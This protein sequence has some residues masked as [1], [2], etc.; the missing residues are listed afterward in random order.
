M[1]AAT[2]PTITTENPGVVNLPHPEKGQADG[3]T[4]RQVLRERDD[5]RPKR[6]RNPTGGDGFSTLSVP[7]LPLD[8]L[9]RL[10]DLA[11]ALG[12]PANRVRRMCPQ[13]VRVIADRCY[14]NL[15]TLWE[16]APEVTHENREPEFVHVKLSP[17]PELLEGEGLPPVVS[18]AEAIRLLGL[19]GKKP[20]AKLLKTRMLEPVQ[21]SDRHVIETSL[22]RAYALEWASRESIKQAARAERLGESVPENLPEQTELVVTV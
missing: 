17:A 4:V 13:A 7:S 6:Y 5:W 16:A 10:R 22:L 19:A 18:Y 15:R 1:I 14:V 12:L 8:G 11:A 21:L 2:I 3:L 9:Y 20:L